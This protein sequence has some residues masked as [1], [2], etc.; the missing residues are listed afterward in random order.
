MRGIAAL[1]LF[2]STSYMKLHAGTP[3]AS[4]PWRDLHDKAMVAFDLPDLPAAIDLL[5]S[6]EDIAQTPVERAVS[7]NDLGLALYRA[8]RVQEARPHLQQALEIW[9]VTPGAF[10]RIAQTSVTI[11]EADRDVGNYASAERLMRDALANIPAARKL[12]APER[13]AKALALEELGDLLREEGRTIESRTLLMQV[14]Q[15]PGVSW[16]RV[17]DSTA[18]LAE[19]DRDARNWEESLAEWNNVAELGR[20]HGDEVLGAVARRGLGVTWLERGDTARAEP[21]LRGALAAFESDPVVNERQVASTLTSMGQLYLGEDKLALAEETLSKALKV[22]EHTFGERHPQL[23]VVLLMLGDSLARRNDMDLARNELGRAVQI[24]SDTF[25]GQSAMVGASLA[26]WGVIEQRSHNPERAVGLFEKSLATFR[27]GNSAELGNLKVFVMQHYAD[28]LK[29]THRK[30]EAS[31][32][33]AA[34]KSFQA[35]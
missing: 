35:K 21:L 7:A 32:V 27:T 1:A 20:D 12:D 19:L 13:D 34:A 23:A 11:A 10:G 14:A 33:L 24:L 16:H 3:E 22:D 26:S 31:A 15:M 2:V 9:K 29:A 18:G 5:K 4:I 30:H 25:G 17:A 6:S 28:V 8:G